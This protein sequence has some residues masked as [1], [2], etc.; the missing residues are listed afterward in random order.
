MNYQQFLTK[1]WQTA[2][3]IQYGQMLI[4]W[5]KLN[6]WTQYTVERWA[7][8]VDFP[9]PSHGNLSCIENAKNLHPR[10]STFLQ[11][12]NVN[13]RVAAQDWGKVKSQ[14]LKILLDGSQPV[15]CDNYGVWQ[16]QHFF[17]LHCG[18]ISPPTFVKK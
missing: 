13:A 4:S 17:M 18:L 16:V 9:F 1:E 2:A 5:R 8:E 10:P 14:E 15:R 7:K 6:G 11:I 12:A 3:A